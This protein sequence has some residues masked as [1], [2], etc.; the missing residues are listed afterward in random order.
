M[1]AHA[2]Q[3]LVFYFSRRHGARN[4][5]DLAQDTIAALLGRSD[6]E[7]EREEEFLRVCYGFAA[8]ISLAEFRKQARQHQSATGFDYEARD[9]RNSAGMNAVETGIWIDQVER[10]GQT[11]MRPEDWQL[12]R[13]SL[14]ASDSGELAEELGLGSA[15]NARVRLFRAFKKLR[16]LLDRGRT[17]L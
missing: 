9:P 15:G 2:R 3:V 7:F 6:F 4:A 12:V 17:E 1:W 14:D 10:I 13:K 11:E 16:A 5:Q 8:M